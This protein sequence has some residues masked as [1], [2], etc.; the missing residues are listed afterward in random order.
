MA[1]PMWMVRAGRGA[2]LIGEFLSEGLVAIGWSKA[3]P[4]PNDVSDEELRRR[5]DE[6]YAHDRPTARLVWRRMVKQFLKVMKVGR[7]TQA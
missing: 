5:F 2:D 4:M 1:K 3:G 6:A 7:M